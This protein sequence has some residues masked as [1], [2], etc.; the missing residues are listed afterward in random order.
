MNDL[1]KFF[2]FDVVFIAATGLFFL[3]LIA[4]SSR[5]ES[6]IKEP[7]YID[8]EKIGKKVLIK[9]YVEGKLVSAVCT[10][11]SIHLVEGK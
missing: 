4:I 5:Q 6:E 2:L 3:I 7:G 9:T 10:N 8:C 11:E 1:E